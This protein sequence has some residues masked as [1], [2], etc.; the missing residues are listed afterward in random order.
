MGKLTARQVQGLTKGRHLD[1]DGLYVYVADS[2]SKSWVQR[3]VVDGRRREIGLGSFPSISLAQARR[4]CL[5]NR[6]SVA[7][8]GDP[9]A[10]KRTPTTPTFK[11]ATYAVLELNRP[12][13]RS[14]KHAANWIQMM[15]KP[16]YPEVGQ[17]GD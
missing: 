12:R 17:H 13:W 1:G 10:A 4:K 15:E 9:L 8:G 6:S 11:D 16:R 14:P 5:A 3:V 2:G 7:N